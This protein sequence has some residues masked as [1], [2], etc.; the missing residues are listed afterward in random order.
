LAHVT[1]DDS[2]SNRSDAV[3]NLPATAAASQADAR[4]AY[5]ARVVSE[6]PPLSDATIDRLAVLLRPRAITA[7]ATP[8]ITVADYQS[9]EIRRALAAEVAA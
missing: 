2:C 4:A 6:A 3:A 1:P 5:I 9:W 7:N 8:T